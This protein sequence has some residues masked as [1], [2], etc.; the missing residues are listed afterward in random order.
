MNKQLTGIKR[1]IK[2]QEQQAKNTINLMPIE[3]YLSNTALQMLAT[4]C[5][6]RYCLENTK[7]R[8]VTG[9]YAP[10]EK[11]LTNL[12]DKTNNILKSLF[13]ARHC[14]S[15]PLGGLQ[16]MDI[17]LTALAEKDMLFLS[18]GKCNGGHAATQKIAKQLGYRCRELPF[19][20]TKQLEIN[21]RLL[22]S[23][24]RGLKF[25][26][27]YLDMSCIVKPVNLKLLRNAVGKHVIICYDG[28]HVLGLIAS[29]NFQ[30]PLEEGADVLCGS[31]HK[32]FFGPQRGI[33][34]TNSSRLWKKISVI[35]ETVVS[36][37]HYNDVAALAISALEMTE[38]GVSY[39]KQVRKNAKE[40][41]KQLSKLDF[42][43]ANKH[44]GYT[45]THQIWVR[46]KGNAKRFVNDAFKAGMILNKYLL[47]GFK[48]PGLRLGVQGVTRLG[49]CELEMGKIACAL[50]Q[51]RVG[52]VQSAKK[53]IKSLT[54]DFKEV[55][56][57]YD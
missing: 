50:N 48:K 26:L 16:A 32:T 43:I 11:I 4:D 40:L 52:N 47:P 9:W 14:T 23:I 18:I 36:N 41:A 51:V 13:N 56:F 8:T 57:S 35:A 1:L 17:I 31:L 7:N 19:K 21:F 24:C 22:K 53:I 54:A 38:F 10:G 55:K 27:V 30:L 45:E 49:M 2:K 46:F 33:I 28:S 3:N 20:N 29:K 15:R 25:G 44:I 37:K 5:V 6:N 42:D 39:S 34:F 12:E